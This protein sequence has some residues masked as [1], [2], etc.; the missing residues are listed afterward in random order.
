L[1][2]P[3][4]ERKKYAGGVQG[5]HYFPK[6]CT[7][8]SY[9]YRDAHAPRRCQ[10]RER[11]EPERVYCSWQGGGS[12]TCITPDRQFYAQTIKRDSLTSDAAN[13][14]ISKYIRRP[15][16][17]LEETGSLKN[18]EWDEWSFVHIQ[19]I[20]AT[21]PIAANLKAKGVGN[22]IA[23]TES[24]DEQLLSVVS[25]LGGGVSGK[26]PSHLWEEA[27]R[28]LGG[29]RTGRSLKQRFER[30]LPSPDVLAPPPSE[31][32]SQTEARHR[33]EVASL[34]SMILYL[35]KQLRRHDDDISDLRRALG[36]RLEETR[37][38]PPT[39]ARAPAAAPPTLLVTPTDALAPPAP[40]TPLGH[41]DS[42]LPHLVAD[43]LDLPDFLT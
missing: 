43:G 28:R 13:I 6:G 39:D 18:I 4:T 31:S 42:S 8:H 2:L 36:A 38:A 24:E 41:F 14:G 20:A 23:W 33:Q 30:L 10:K 12:W 15:C 17:P 22:R 27:A 7:A 40:P 3:D 35:Q 19:M 21:G 5:C 37:G 34:H 1:A 29:V 32:E 25:V 16:T 26:L 9:F 11:E